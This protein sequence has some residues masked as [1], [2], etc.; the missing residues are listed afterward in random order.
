MGV[1]TE[2]V[3]VPTEQ[4]PLEVGPRLALFTGASNSLHPFDRE[5][6]LLLRSPPR[7]FPTL[8]QIRE[9]HEAGNGQRQYD[10]AIDNEQ[11]SPTCSTV[12]A[13]QM[14][15]GGSLQETAD[16][17]PARISWRTYQSL[18]ECTTT[19]GC[20]GCQGKIRIWLR[21]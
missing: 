10:N 11:P 3:R 21:V 6:V 18:G 15:I 5:D 9:E 20:S 14:R 7:P 12:H 17:R 13:V 4:D 8:W 2:P 19:R 16:S 1:R